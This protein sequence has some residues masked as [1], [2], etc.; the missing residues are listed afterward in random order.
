MKYFYHILNEFF[1][2]STIHGLT[3]IRKD[4]YNGTRIFWALV[5]L[6]AFSIAS[7]FLSQ[8]IEGYNTKFTSTTIGTKSVK[9]FPFPAVTFFPGDHNSEKAFKRTFFNQFLFARDLRTDKSKLLKD[10]QLFMSMF[11]WL[12]SPMHEDIFEAIEKYL[13]LEEKFINRN[14]KRFQDE[15]CGLVALQKLRKLNLRKVRNH[16]CQLHGKFKPVNF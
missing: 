2:S 16:H 3:Y 11:E 4:Q 9:E 8:T 12:I 13:L 14:G 10:D 15:V 7:F 6:A 1:Q 5:V